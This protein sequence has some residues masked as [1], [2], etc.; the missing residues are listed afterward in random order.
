MLRTLARMS[1]LAIAL[2]LATPALAA[3]K[4]PPPADWQFSAD[5]AVKRSAELFAYLEQFERDSK[6]RAK[7]AAG[8]PQKLAPKGREPSWLKKGSWIERT[9]KTELRFGV[10][11][12]AGIKN[13]ALAASTASNRAR[14]EIAKLQSIE[15]QSRTEGDGSKTV[16]TTTT[17]VLSGVE[18]IDYFQASDDT[19][20][21]LAMQTVRQE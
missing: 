13:P 11:I 15:V 18:I 17:A 21:A 4:P 20:Y 12:V 5:A 10:G 8:L 9:G 7:A 19:W 3:D 2:P 16:K 14:A 6:E 1:L